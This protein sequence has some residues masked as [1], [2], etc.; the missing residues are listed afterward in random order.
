MKKIIATVLCFVLALSLF[1]CTTKDVQSIGTPAVPEDA[2]TMQ[3]TILE[4]GNGEMII[5]P[6]EGSDEL[7]SADKYSV[8]MEHMDAS[9]EPQAGYLVEITYDGSIE[10]TYP[11]KLGTVYFVKV[12]VQSDNSDCREFNPEGVKIGVDNITYICTGVEVPVEPNE[13]TIEYVEIPVSGDSAITAFARIE[14]DNDNYLV[15]LI[16]DEW[17]KFITE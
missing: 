17:F 7:T 1:G 12:V 9:P 3:G 14:D 8:P 11:A 13:S 5:E 4:I 10:E 6:V 16:G 15:C 2:V